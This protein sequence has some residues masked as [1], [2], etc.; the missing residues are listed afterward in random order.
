MWLANHCRFR[1]RSSLADKSFSVN[2]ILYRCNY[3]YCVSVLYLRVPKIPSSQLV[4][5][6]IKQLQCSVVAG[7]CSHDQS[8]N[9]SNTSDEMTVSRKNSTLEG[10]SQVM[11]IHQ[12]LNL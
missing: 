4:E 2:G 1:K 9:L 3:V 8:A 7:S 5:D 12:Q 11:S 10:L 6:K